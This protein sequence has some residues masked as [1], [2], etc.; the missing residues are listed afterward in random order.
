MEVA[1]VMPLAKE[2]LILQLSSIRMTNF[3]CFGEE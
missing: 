1:N 3:T 2:R